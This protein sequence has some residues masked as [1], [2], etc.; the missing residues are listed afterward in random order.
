MASKQKNKGKVLKS[1]ERLFASGDSSFAKEYLEENGYNADEVGKKGAVF[2][3]ELV[4]AK[5]RAIY[6]KKKESQIDW[7][8]KSVLQLIKNNKQLGEDPI[9]IIKEKSRALILDAFTRGWLGPPFDVVQL[10]QMNNIQISPYELVPDARILPVRE[11]Q[12]K[13]EYNPFQSPARINFSIA[14]EI[15]HTLFAD[16]AETVRNREV[17]LED[18]SWQ[19]EFLCNVAAS[20]LLLPYAEFS[21]EAN[22]IE[23]TI[24]SLISLARKYNASVESVLLRFC[25]VVEKPCTMALASFNT[26]GELRVEYSK[27]SPMS[28]ISLP[29]GFLVPLTSN[30]YDCKK[31]GETSHKLESWE[32]FKNRKYRVYGAG[33]SPIRK[34]TTPRVGIIIVPEAYDTTPSRGIYWV[35]GDA[36]MPRGAG[37]KVIGQVV[38]TSG[39]LGFGFG[40]AIAEKF[41]VAKKELQEWKK[42]KKTFRLGN[43][44]MIKVND[45]LYIFQML[46]QEGIKPKFGS[47]PLRYNS[48]RNCLKTLCQEA[49]EMNATIHIPAIGAGQAKGDWNVIKGMIHDELVKRG[50]DVTI[51]MR[52]GTNMKPNES[53]TLIIFKEDAK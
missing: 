35:T 16:C 9:T 19:L 49:L 48:L 44:R 25:E 26:K 13:I 18:E 52:Q 34:Q 40:R 23:L 1:V 6:F 11:N 51:Y 17:K 22:E 12:F 28:D 15:G 24:D 32:I 2:V 50:V 7:T 20:E 30:V 5:K 37:V 38:N 29:R 43:S 27:A 42:D 46:A 41:P 31:S 10:A 8:H 36:T 47:V 33:L 14:H 53:R 3:K 45:D 4:E 39:A 21:V